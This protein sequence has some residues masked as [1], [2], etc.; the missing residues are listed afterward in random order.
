MSPWKNWSGNIEAP[1]S[2]ENYFSPSTLSELQGIVSR[3]TAN[4]IPKHRWLWL[5]IVAT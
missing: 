2:N 5:T 1:I 3:A 4:G